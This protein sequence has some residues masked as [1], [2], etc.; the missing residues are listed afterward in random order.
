[1][2]TD[3]Q[4]K[5]NRLSSAPPPPQKAKHDISEALDAEIY[6]DENGA[7][8]IIK[9]TEFDIG[10]PYGDYTVENVE[11]VFGLQNIAFV[12]TET[13]GLGSAACP[14]LIGTAY[15][16]NNKLILEQ[17]FMRDVDDEEAV[18]RYFI[19]KFRNYT[20][21][22]F[23][24]KSFD[25]PLIKSRC[26]IN[27]VSPDGFATEQY[28]LLHLSRRIWRKRLESCRLGNIEEQI[29]KFARGNDID[30]SLIPELYKE[31]LKTGK[32]DDIIDIVEHNKHDIITLGI[33]LARLLRIEQNPVEELENKLDLMHLG[34]SYFNR[35]E[36]GK[37]ME[38]LT[39][40]IHSRTDPLTLYTAMK[41]IS[42]I[43][44]HNK[45]YSECILYWTRM[46]KMAIGAIFPLI[47]LAKYYEHTG[48]DTQKALAYAERAR[49][50]ILKNNSKE[51][52]TEINIRIERLK[53][54]IKKTKDG[55][56]NGT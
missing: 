35:K 24:G 32:P 19:N 31:Y 40:V 45:S 9:V 34:E 21:V 1:M 26:I 17:L 4:K 55:N 29:L 44:K 20:V 5:L 38:C 11:K 28:D 27:T 52:I 3:L 46:D 42:L 41:Y 22:T 50:I 14:F 51:Q 12:D 30:G 43:H 25:V 39:A 47:E 13:T 6:T 36:Y 7:A 15:Y 2:I 54:K 8:F 49:G 16:D 33:L 23:N 48:K 10:M 18:L 53:N 37:A 56:K